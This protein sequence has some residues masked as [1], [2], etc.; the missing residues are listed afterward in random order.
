MNH[1][2]LMNVVNTEQA[3][4]QTTQTSTTAPQD[5]TLE[6]PVLVTGRDGQEV[7]YL[8]VVVPTKPQIIASSTA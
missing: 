1:K 7:N 3:E 2:P 8:Y 6:G 4:E 5:F